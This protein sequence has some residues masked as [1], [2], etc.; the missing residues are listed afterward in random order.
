[1]K[2]QLSGFTIPFNYN[3]IKCIECCWCTWHPGLHFWAMAL[4]KWIMPSDCS[5]H[6]CNARFLKSLPSMEGAET[7]VNVHIEWLLKLSDLSDNWN[8]L[9][10]FWKTLSPIQTLKFTEIHLA[11]LSCFRYTE[12]HKHSKGLS[13]TA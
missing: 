3:L 1:M 10:K 8:N 6:T 12:I 2:F 9:T 5:G 4:L 13:V 11:L 7:H